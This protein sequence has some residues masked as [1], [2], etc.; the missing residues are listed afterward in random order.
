MKV[1]YLDISKLDNKSTL[2]ITEDSFFV[3]SPL[4][5]SAKKT[6]ILEIAK[7]KVNLKLV[8]AT[9]IINSKL[10]LEILVKHKSPKTKSDIKVRTILEE[11]AS[12]K[13]KGNIKMLK[14]AKESTGSLDIKGL[15]ADENISWEVYPNLE[16][17]NKDIKAEHKASLTSFS[18]KQ[19]AYLTSRGLSEEEAL[20]ELKKGFLKEVLEKI[21]ENKAKS[22][23]IG[24]L[25]I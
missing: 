12:F 17:N 7:S 4:K 11:N 20:S 10:D 3:L 19:V 22:N 13:F 24:K 6:L 16:I 15:S 8:F 5:E 14:R 25:R 1:K 23:I 18:K 9:T 21:P 2:E